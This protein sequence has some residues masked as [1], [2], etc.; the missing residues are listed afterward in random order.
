ME[1]LPDHI[2]LFDGQCKF[3]NRS[4]QFILKYDR[5]KIFHFAPLQSDFGQK[6]LAKSPF[7][8]NALDSIVLLK[9]GKYFS[10]SDAAIHIGS[11]L[12]AGFMLLKL[13]F[14]FPRFLR[15]FIYRLI[16]KNRHRLMGRKATCRIPSADERARFLA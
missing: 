2:V 11:D 15:D 7:D 16:A 12:G 3:C 13:L 14:I 5:K 10:H 8:P 9:K 4:V 1:N 6:L